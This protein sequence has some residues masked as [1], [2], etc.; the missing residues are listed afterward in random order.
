M[1][2]DKYR[3]YRWLKYREPRKNHISIF[4]SSWFNNDGVFDAEM[5]ILVFKEKKREERINGKRREK[6]AERPNTSLDSGYLSFAVRLAIPGSSGKWTTE[7]SVR[8]I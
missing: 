3:I 1:F 2:R 5:V 6:E 7:L 8:D 4:S